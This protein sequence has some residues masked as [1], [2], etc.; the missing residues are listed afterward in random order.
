MTGKREKGMLLEMNQPLALELF[1]DFLCPEKG[2][3]M[4]AQNQLNVCLDY[5]MKD[6][7]LTDN[8]LH[9]NQH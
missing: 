5:F 3:H 1:Q 4:D 7:I 2:W 9:L 8:E 6:L